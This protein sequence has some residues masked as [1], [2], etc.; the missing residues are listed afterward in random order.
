MEELYEFLIIL[1]FTFW[2]LLHVCYI[3]G[4]EYM[5]K[6]GKLLHRWALVNE[7]SMYI[8]WKPESDI[9]RVLYKDFDDENEDSQWKEV[10]Y[11]QIN[12]PS[13]ILNPNMRFHHFLVRC[14]VKIVDAKKTKSAELPNKA[15][16][17]YLCAVIHQ[18][19]NTESKNFRKLKIELQTN[20]MKTRTVI[21]SENLVL[22]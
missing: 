20:E 13:L 22:N 9:Y 11:N 4:R 10:A 14:K 1:I 18:L 16:F 6:I 17:D 15:V 21:S 5:G 3:F 19:P 8:G 12:F 7:W 2:L